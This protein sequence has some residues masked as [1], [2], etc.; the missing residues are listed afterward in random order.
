MSTAEHDGRPFLAM[1][2]LPG[3]SLFQRLK[4]TDIRDPIVAARTIGK[5]ARALQAARDL[6]IVHRDLKPGNVLFDE[7]GEPKVTDFGLAKR[8]SGKDLTATQ[9]VMGTPGYMAP[10]QAKGDTKFVGPGADIY[11]LGVI[12]YECLSGTRPFNDASTMALL[13]K[14]AEEE[15]QRIRKRMP[16]VPRDVEL[17]C[18]KCLAKDPAD[19]YP[20]ALALADDLRRFAA[21][22]PVSVRAAGLFER[23]YKWTRRKPVLAGL[24][25]LAATAVVLLTFGGIVAWL[26]WDAVLARRGA[27]EERQKTENLLV[28]SQGLEKD[29]TRARTEAET[30]R[31]KLDVEKKQT[32]EARDGEKQARAAAERALEGEEKARGEAVD[33][34]NL[35]AAIEYGRTLQVAHQEWRE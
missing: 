17:I 33:A 32:E 19:R 23:G 4:T 29:A 13:R 22:E 14:V 10:E 24:Y 16:D 6:G 35:L 5:L 7:A 8:G 1:E 15:P 34:R 30:A 2:Y 26:W 31:D 11:S 28:L 18:L 3:R 21:G 12:L 25:A 20:T 9:V 27:D